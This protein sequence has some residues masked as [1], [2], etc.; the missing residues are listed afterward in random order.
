MLNRRKLIRNG[1][2]AGTVLGLGGRF[3]LG[4]SAVQSILLSVNGYQ[5]DGLT[6]GPKTGELVLCNVGFPE[7]VDSLI[8][9]LQALGQ[10]GYYAVA[11]NPRGYSVAAQP[12]DPSLYTDAHLSSDLV[13]FA[14]AL[15]YE[16]FHLVGQD[17]GGLNAAS[18]AAQYPQRVLT[19]T[20]LG[21][22]PKNAFVSALNT[23]PDQQSK[24]AYI[25]YFQKTPPPAPEQSLLGNNGAGLQSAYQGILAPSVVQSYITRFMQSS[26]QLT[27]PLNWYR[28][29]DFTVAQALIS[30]PTTFIWGS[31]DL[32]Y[33]KTAAYNVA[34][35]CTGPY[36]FFELPGK[37]HW[38]V[39]EVP[40]TIIS[41][42][43]MQ[44]SSKGQL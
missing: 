43:Q 15:G 36:Q 38:L 3:A 37:S 1:L 11:M 31:A 17:W 20:A 44:L 18:V 5:F 28:A 33:G 32:Y 26:S 4:Q 40:D 39:D 42:L 24:S 19:L 29:Y 2:A 7:F 12:V 30:V 41:I 35:C 22:G 9:I 27:G 10:M 13:G 34:S 14:D 21:G 8:P 6:A 23:D 16:Q 25:L